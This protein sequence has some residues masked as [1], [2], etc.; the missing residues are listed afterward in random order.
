MIRIS[1]H[2]GLLQ[3]ILTKYVIN[4]HCKDHCNS[5]TGEC[6][7]ENNECEK[8]Y[9]KGDSTI[10][11]SCYKGYYKDSSDKYISTFI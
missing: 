1:A 2:A 6:I 5:S 4:C 3:S 10:C 9:F 7:G 11:S 8:G